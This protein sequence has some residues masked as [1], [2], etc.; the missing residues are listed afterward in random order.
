MLNAKEIDDFY[1]IPIDNRNLNY[2]QYYS[3]GEK[4]I[5]NINDY[6]SHNANQKNIEGIKKLLMKLPVIQNDLSIK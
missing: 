5:A 2:A 3:E 1:C 6:H 4:N